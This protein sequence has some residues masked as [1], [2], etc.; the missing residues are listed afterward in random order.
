MLHSNTDTTH[1][2]LQFLFADL[3]NSCRMIYEEVMR[4][5]YQAAAE[6][7]LTKHLL[8]IG[9]NVSSIG[10]LKDVSII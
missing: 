4:C 2:I 5:D 1:I 7:Y 8:A 10:K 9:N 3:A 6:M